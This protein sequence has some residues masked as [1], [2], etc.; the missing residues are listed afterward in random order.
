[1]AKSKN[2]LFGFDARGTIAKVLTFRR[3]KQQTIAEKTP[4]PKDA[5][6]SSQ[7]SWR[8]MYQQ[9]T[10]LWHLLTAAEKANWESL[11]RSHHMT[12]Y[13]Y[14]MSQCLRPNPG[15]YLP[16]AG[17]TM[18]GDIAMAA[19]KTVDGVDISVHAADPDAHH[20]QEIPWGRGKWNTTR[21]LSIP[22]TTV[23]NIGDLSPAENY[24]YYFP[25]KVDT[26][27][28]I[29]Q[30]VIEIITEA[31][32]GSKARLGIYKAD[33]DWQP[34]SLVVDAGEV[35]IDA[36][37]VVA[38]T[39]NVTLQEGRYLLAYTSNKEPTLR[40]VWA[41]P[42]LIGFSPTLGEDTMV[43]FITVSQ[44]YAALADP[45]IAWDTIEASADG[46]A[47]WVFVRVAT[48]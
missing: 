8:T 29:D 33:I 31:E 22:G 30:L 14:Y 32:E 26:P 17:G 43:S 10:G 4:I 9:C 24:I 15:I 34:T 6:T 36:I 16:L 41:A 39:V 23:Y 47:Y 35:A 25:I 3:G 38:A 20:H 21:A 7:L 40:T 28:T 46:V 11:A 2:F 45:G 19:L 48:P 44:G 5:K 27:I 18:S 12:G 13:A 37:A 42:T 1:M